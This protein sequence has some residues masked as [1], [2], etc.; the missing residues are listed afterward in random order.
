MAAEDEKSASA[1]E[2]TPESP[3]SKGEYAENPS[4]EEAGTPAPLEG[5]AWMYKPI[6]LGPLTL[7]WFASPPSQ[8]TFVALVC[9]LCPGMYNA[10]NGLGAG[11]T[12]STHDIDNATVAT[13]STF[14]GVGF[15]AGSIANRIGLK[16]TLSIGGFGYFLYVA[17]IL[18][19]VHNGNVGFLI[20]AGALLGLCAALLW[21]AQGA[22]M[23]S[24]PAEEHKG[25]YISWFWMIFNL[26]AVIGSLVPLGENM[27]KEAGNVTDGTYIAFL[28][29]MASGFVLAWGLI[30]S[31]K[32]RR[33]DG[34]HV[35]VMKNPTWK[36]E[37][38]GL[39]EVLRTDSYIILLFPMFFASNWFYAYHFNGYNFAKFNVRT[40]ALNN[41]LYYLCQ[42]FGAYIFGYALDVKSVSRP[43]KAKILVGVLFTLTMVIWG[44]GYAVQKGYTRASTDPKKG[45]KG[46]DFEDSG[47]VGLMFLYMFYGFYDSVWQTSA[48]W[49]VS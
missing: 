6:K 34:S 5:A 26:G 31:R 22:I 41:T 44:G 33:A 30:D 9:F 23:M 1:T 43:L 15:F 48:Y 39:F 37:I 4:I 28:V 38:L 2:N 13:Y 42:I 36:T 3:S 17:S 35:V 46:M 18:S 49:Y 12:I 7:P 8:L 29:L 20:F 10:V 47:Y 32:I 14:A 27:H 11:G 24:Y 21:T 45:F 25:K 40:R 19:Y 16:L